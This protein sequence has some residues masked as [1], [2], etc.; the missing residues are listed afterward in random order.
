MLPLKLDGLY[1]KQFLAGI[2]FRPVQEAED[3][4]NI[5]VQVVV[6]RSRQEGRA[7]EKLKGRAEIALPFWRDISSRGCFALIKYGSFPLHYLGGGASGIYL[8]LGE[9]HWLV[10]EVQEH[11]NLIIEMRA[12][13]TVTGYEAAI[14]R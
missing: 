4:P 9:K 5:C 10:S 6:S 13:S 11:F 8:A 1:P 2:I 7:V 12:H 14:A 3:T